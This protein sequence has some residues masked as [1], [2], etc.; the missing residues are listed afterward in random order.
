MATSKTPSED[1]TSLPV[2]DG[3]SAVVPKL[4]DRFADESY[5]LL[6]QIKVEAPNPEEAEIIRKKCVRWIIPF[7]CIG[8]HLM[9]V[10]KQT[11]SLSPM[12]TTKTDCC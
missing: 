8:Y 12:L 1:T 4:S 3:P 11:V 9:Y 6:S 5:K 7:I 10:D 2:E